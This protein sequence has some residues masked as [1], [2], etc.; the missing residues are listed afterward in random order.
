MSSFFVGA[1]TVVHLLQTTQVQQGMSFIA[2]NKV[3]TSKNK[4]QN[5]LNRDTT[6]FLSLFFKPG[7]DVP[8]VY[9]P[10]WVLGCFYSHISTQTFWRALTSCA[11]IKRA[12]SVA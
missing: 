2:A 9:V 6:L 5:R 10:A 11:E 8:H 7:V 4:N 3:Y 1:Q 12:P